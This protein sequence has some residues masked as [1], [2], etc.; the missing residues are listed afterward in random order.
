MT[1]DRILITGSTGFVGGYL[2]TA[3]AAQWPDAALIAGDA[4]VTDAAAVH[5]MIEAARPDA[6]V[7]LAGIASVPAARL[8]P[9]RAFAVNLGGSLAVARALIDTA[10]TCLMVHVGSAECYGGSFRTGVALD[11]TAALAP[12]N[13]YAA[14]KAAADL[15]LGAMAAESGL[16][17]VR[18]RP[19]NHTG[20][21]QSD[22]FVIPAFAAQ[23]AAIIAGSQ[24]PVIKVGNLD[25]ARDFLDV[26]D[27]VRAYTLAIARANDLPPGTIFNLASGTPR[28]IGDVLH[29]MISAAG[30]PITVEIDP[31]RLRPVDIPS[32]FGDA[33][34]ADRSLGWR[35]TID[36]TTTLQDMLTANTRPERTQIP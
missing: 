26:R 5:R 2:R 25:A 34:A 18:F 32:A 28:R 23:I 7:H 17:L 11:E 15:A 8:A 21:G 4:D 14:T 27:I 31:A 10:P 19:F 9:D 16:R 12:L 13:T 3:L 30:R 29:T 36:L 1:P 6:V 20:P 22:A 33:S 24:P 35:P